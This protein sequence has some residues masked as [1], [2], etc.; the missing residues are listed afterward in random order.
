[1]DAGDFAWKTPR[2]AGARL[3]QQRR[4]A[5]LQL[6]AFAKGGMDALLPGDGDLALDPAWLQD[7]ARS[8]GVPLVLANVQC[9]GA[10]PFAPAAVVDRGGVK[11]LVVG[12]MGE[13]ARVPPSCRL[14]KAR[15]A[16]EAVLGAAGPVDLVVVLSHQDAEEDAAL[17]EAVPAT[18]LFINAGA[19]ASLSEPR[20]LPG[21]ALQLAAGSRGKK[22]GI[23]TI[24]L[25]PGATGFEN[26]GATQELAGRLDRT[27]VRLETAR[28]Q[29]EA[30]DDPEKRQRSERRARFFEEEVT[31]L[32]AELEVV[33][34]SK[35]EPRNVLS[36]VLKGL[37]ETVADDPEVAAMLE[38]AK[39]E[40]GAAAHAGGAPADPH[41]GHDHGAEGAAAHAASPTVY[42]GSQA[43]AGCH[44][45][46]AAQW[47]QTPH[48]RAWASLEAE[49]RQLDLDCWSCHATGAE[50]PGGPQH[51]TQVGAALQGVGCE[52]CHGPG[53]EHAKRPKDHEMVTSP[54]EATCT[55]CHDGEQ[56]GGR[57]D[58]DTYQPKVVHGAP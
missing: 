23:A 55:G 22:L 44:P 24:T 6:A 54:P 20:A 37:G 34:A 2:I 18:D 33:L 7:A 9:D 35:T 12:L 53:A 17:A 3:P 41:A 13:R 28:Q 32:E 14:S 42:A 57:F 39:P 47:T 1:M 16:L 29:I 38:A 56:D 48:A 10:E 26:E 5:E 25:H 40:I 21:A 49:N 15:P 50:K 36:N 11:T 4:K 46:P 51:P 43:C 45:G 52:S 27:R 31:R 19:G 30:T 8:A 58:H